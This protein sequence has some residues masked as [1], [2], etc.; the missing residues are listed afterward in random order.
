VVVASLFPLADFARHVA[1]DRAVVTSLVPPGVEPHDWEPSPRDV[2]EVRKAT[3]FVYSGAGFEEAADR[4]LQELAGGVGPVPVDAS[5]GLTLLEAPA[6]GGPATAAARVKDPH[7]WLDPLLAQ[8]QVDAIAE[9]LARV[10]PAGARTYRDNA[11]AYRARLGEL[12]DAFTAGLA[13]CARREVVTSHAAFGY[14]TAR[15]GLVQ[16]PVMGIAPESEPSPADLARLV[17]FAR[18]RQ[19]THI[20][21]ESLVSPRVAET[22]A[23][24]LG[25]KTLVLNPVEGLTQEEAV[26]GRDYLALMRTNLDHL[27]TA[28][29][30]R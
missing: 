5:A 26:A 6:G 10:D 17:R 11:A 19:V 24:E 25:A 30:C 1:G 16:M 12:H 15:Y 13:R 3:L 28:L 14:L 21:F 4:I 7:V 2:A 29:G 27:R 8:R 22:L 23:R 20:F 18:Q 9:G